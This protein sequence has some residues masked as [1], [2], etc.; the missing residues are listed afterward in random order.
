MAIEKD[1]T[2]LDVSQP[3]SEEGGIVSEYFEEN[4]HLLTIQLLEV[5]K[6]KALIDTFHP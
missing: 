1:I 5:K 6:N 2:D 4:W 3:I